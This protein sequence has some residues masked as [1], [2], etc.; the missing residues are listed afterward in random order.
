MA[1]TR[2]PKPRATD[3]TECDAAVWRRAM[4]T[5]RP[6]ARRD[7]R[8]SGDAAGPSGDVSLP[9]PDTRRSPGSGPVKPVHPSGAP[10][11]A[12]RAP[13]SA[14]ERETPA[15]LDKHLARQVRRGRREVDARLDLHGLTQREAH[16]ALARFIG[17]AAARGDRLVLVITGKG[18]RGGGVLQ[19][20]VPRWLARPDLAR[21]VVGCEPALARDGGAGALYVHLRRGAAPPRG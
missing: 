4:R 21:S 18:S 1:D 20:E 12:G 16:A 8:A 19:R 11:T 15:K 9:E 3:E 14:A 5:T 6:I 13:G 2:R 7:R 10:P 17:S